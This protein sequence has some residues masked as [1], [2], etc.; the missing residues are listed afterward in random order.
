MKNALDVHRQL[1][2]DG[3]PHEVV[4]LAS[5]ILTADD[6]PRVLGVPAAQCVSVRCYTVVSPR[7]SFAAVLVPAGQTPDPVAL[8][9]AL[10]AAKVLPATATQVNAVTEYAAGLVSPI[11]LPPDVALLADSGLGAGDVVYAAM[12]EGGVALGIRTRDLLV[13]VDARVANLT[14]RVPVQTAQVLQLMPRVGRRRTG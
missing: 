14:T 6:L 4:R 9:E 11:C 13:A 3:V 1:L 5:T 10:D 12:G 2:A 7:W 8:L